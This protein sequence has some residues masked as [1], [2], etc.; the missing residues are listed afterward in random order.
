MAEDERAIGL[1]LNRAV[2]VDVEQCRLHAAQRQQQQNGRQPGRCPCPV[3]ETLPACLVS[4]ASAADWLGARVRM[5]PQLLF[6]RILNYRLANFNKR[7]PSD[8]Q[9]AA[10]APMPFAQSAACF[11]SVGCGS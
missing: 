9:S 7:L 10:G 3:S 5:L 1:R 2:T 11:A 8:G 4:P 6:R